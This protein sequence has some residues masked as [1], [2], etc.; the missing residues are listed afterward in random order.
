MKFIDLINESNYE[1]K[2]RLQKRAIDF[3]KH[4]RI[5]KFKLK[6][7]NT[8]TFPINNDETIEHTVKV[9]LPHEIKIDWNHRGDPLIQLNGIVKIYYPSE[10]GEKAVH[11]LQNQLLEKC[12][13]YF[14]KYRIYISTLHSFLYQRIPMENMLNEMTEDVQLKKATDVYKFLRRGTIE[15]EPLGNTDKNKVVI[16]Y[17]LPSVENVHVGFNEIR[18]KPLITFKDEV[19]YE[20]INS[21]YELTNFCKGE[22]IETII[23]RFLKYNIILVDE[24]EGHYQTFRLDYNGPDDDELLDLY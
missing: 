10:M 4:A 11:D 2:P 16:K 24:N 20:V 15:Y 19:K 21:N 18:T 1:D 14:E 5:R 8:N 22:L 6:Q 9:E 23:L 7:H 3:Y 12:K 17:E 13:K